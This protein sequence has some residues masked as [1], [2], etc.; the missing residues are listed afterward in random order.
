MWGSPTKTAG[1]AELDPGGTQVRMG[2][3]CELDVARGRFFEA[4]RCLFG[5]N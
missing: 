4:A 3:H 2:V 5:G 1:G